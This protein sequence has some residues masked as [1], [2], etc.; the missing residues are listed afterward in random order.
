MSINFATAANCVQ[1][2]LAN[3]SNSLRKDPLRQGLILSTAGRL[4]EP[5]NLHE[6]ER[7]NFALLRDAIPSDTGLSA[8]VD[9]PLS[10]SQITRPR[11]TLWEAVV[12]GGQSLTTLPF[13]VVMWRTYNMEVVRALA[14]EIRRREYVKWREDHKEKFD[15]V[16][17]QHVTV[18]LG[19]RTQIAELN[20]TWK[21]EIKEIERELGS[22]K[23]HLAKSKISTQMQAGAELA[24]LFEIRL[25]GRRERGWYSTV[26]G[27]SSV[28]TIR[29]DAASSQDVSRVNFYEGKLRKCRANN[30]TAE[31]EQR[32]SALVEAGPDY[33]KFPWTE[34]ELVKPE[35]F[36][37]KLGLTCLVAPGAVVETM[38]SPLRLDMIQQ[39]LRD[40]F[41]SVY[42]KLAPEDP[43]LRVSAVVCVQMYLASLGYEHQ[44][45]AVLEEKQAM[46]AEPLA[47]R[48]GHALLPSLV[49]SQA[50]ENA[51][52]F[53]LV[54]EH[55]VASSMLTVGLRW[56][57]AAGG[58]YKDRL[59]ALTFE[60]SSVYSPYCTPESEVIALARVVADL[61]IKRS[62]TTDTRF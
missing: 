13:E 55:P 16:E 15:F 34:E 52:L 14:G 58:K 25:D 54:A 7:A 8:Q 26:A 57:V 38:F 43:L 6:L 20:K 59:E 35:N 47:R 53:R 32:L 5:Q 24:E 19:L 42:G 49:R 1:G 10:I 48:L 12:G 21:E 51:L 23:A 11:L 61:A 37:A 9:G 33:P 22:A 44:M 62:A 60:L 29:D 40:N 36:V 45:R 3:P 2:A 46:L 56:L 41:T 50:S 17:Q 27:R 18:V 39:E 31:L 28:A 4:K 30:P